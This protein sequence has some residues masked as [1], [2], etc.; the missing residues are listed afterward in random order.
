MSISVAIGEGDLLTDFFS[1][2]TSYVRLLTSFVAKPTM[3]KPAMIAVMRVDISKRLM[4]NAEKSIGAA[5]EEVKTR[6][7]A[8]M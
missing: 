5:R 7:R 3:I 4:V 1:W 6:A 8:F 2:S